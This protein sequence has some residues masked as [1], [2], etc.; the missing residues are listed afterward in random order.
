MR[1]L[2]F[3]AETAVLAAAIAL[4][5]ASL[6]SAGVLGIPCR[7]PTDQAGTADCP[8]ATDDCATCVAGPN[9]AGCSDPVCDGEQAVQDLFACPDN[10]PNKTRC[11]GAVDGNNNPIK[12]T[13]KNKYHC[14]IAN[15]LTGPPYTCT[16]DLGAYIQSST[17]QINT[18]VNCT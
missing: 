16:I 3:I 8:D 7:S 4:P 15:P 12:N 1:V 9:G 17:K 14:K 2:L 6:T 10:V 13:C 5:V 11:V 18:T